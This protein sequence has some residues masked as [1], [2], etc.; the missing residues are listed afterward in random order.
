VLKLSGGVRSP[1]PEPWWN[2]DRRA[3]PEAQAGGN[4]GR[5][6]AEEMKSNC[7][8]RRSASLFLWFVF[9][10]SSLFRSSFHHPSLSGIAV[11]RT[12]SFHSPMP[13]IHAE[14]KLAASFRRRSSLHLS[15]D[16]R[17]KSSGD[18]SR[19]CRAATRA[20]PRRENGILF[21]LPPIAVRRTA[22]L[23]SPMRSAWWGGR[24]RP[25]AAVLNSNDA[26][27]KHRQ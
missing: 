20:Q 23:R 26:D 3:A 18:E 16:R 24:R 25:T 8:C 14:P 10:R 1:K 11:G 7:V 6:G 17:I 5:R 9:F 15:M 4:I 13:A 2:A 21:P 27:A 19:K 12:A 22:S